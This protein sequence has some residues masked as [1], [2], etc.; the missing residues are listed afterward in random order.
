M[1]KVHHIGIVV[2][3]I[4]DALPVYTR[5]LGLRL[6]TI[7]EM[8]EQR[9]NI[10][11]L[12]TAAGEIELVQ[13]TDDTS[14]TAKFLASRGEGIHHICLEVDDITSTLLQ[15]AAAGAELIDKVPRQGAS[16]L[17]AFVHPKSTH[18]VLVE[19]LQRG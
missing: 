7:K 16:G 3:S 19:L 18:G 4:E 13:P 9:V 6:Q 2:K 14:G 12:P 11:F 8:P 15:L 17:V 1:I 10:A 5:G